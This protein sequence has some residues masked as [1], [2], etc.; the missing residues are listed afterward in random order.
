MSSMIT[1]EEYRE[2]ALS[3][4]DTVELPHF[5]NPSFRV[6]NKIFATYWIK[7]NRAMVKLSPVDQSVFCSF[8]KTVFFPVPGAWGKRGATFIELAKVRKDI[9]K[10]ALT[11]AYHFVA[12]TKP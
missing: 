9:F 5:D 1:L 11:T 3:L 4:P 12:G 7:D 10:D 8:D 6:N 2:L